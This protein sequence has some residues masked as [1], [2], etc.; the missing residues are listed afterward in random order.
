[1]TEFTPRPRFGGIRNRAVIIANNNYYI[2]TNLIT[3][4]WKFSA[5]QIVFCA[6][7]TLLWPTSKE[8][9]L[10]QTFLEM[11]NFRL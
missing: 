5:I 7:V 3:V 2:A 6:H 4:N 1:M 10:R 9:F 8:K 11:I